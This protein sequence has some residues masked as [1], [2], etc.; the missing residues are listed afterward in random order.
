VLS[1]VINSK[2]LKAAGIVLALC[3]I[4]IL[5]VSL[6]KSTQINRTNGISIRVT[7]SSLMAAIS[8]AKCTIEYSNPNGH[9]ARADLA[10]TLCEFPIMVVPM[11]NS[12]YFFCIYYNDI[13]IQL[14]KFCPGLPF[15]PL[16]QD[17][18][19]RSDVLRSTCEVKRVAKGDT[20]DWAFVANS[21]KV[22]S[23]QQFE[24]Q[25][26]PLADF[27]VYR[28]FFDRTRLVRSLVNYGD[29]GQYPGDVFVPWYMK[30]GHGSADGTATNK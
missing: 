28:R 10:Q 19:I 11:T 30:D 21:L 5:S 27:K 7:R 14:M 17:D 4:A 3:A 26:I 15:K 29:Q 24:K 2:I 22:M 25:S 20:D 18:P 23:R 16:P 6:H 9:D 12:D 1:S 13:D 8:G